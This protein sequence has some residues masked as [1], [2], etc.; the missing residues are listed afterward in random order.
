MPSKFLKI[1]L[2]I[3]AISPIF[4]IQLFIKFSQNWNFTNGLIWILIFIICITIFLIILKNLKTKLEIFKIQISKIK[5]ID[6][7]SFTF[8]FLYLIPLLN[9]TNIQLIFTI[10]ILIIISYLSN[11]CYLNPIFNLFGYHFF[12]ITNKNKKTYTLISKQKHINKNEIMDVSFLND[13]FLIN[14]KK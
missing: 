9:L 2:S 5:N 6:Y 10:I 11:I 14:L 8:V 13:Y 3:I 1:L 4:L 12:E 7:K